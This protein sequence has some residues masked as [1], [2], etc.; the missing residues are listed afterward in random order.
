MSQQAAQGQQG[1]G[2]L[3]QIAALPGGIPNTSFIG[4]QLTTEAGSTIASG[5]VLV[6]ISGPRNGVYENS[7]SQ[8]QGDLVLRCPHLEELQETE[9]IKALWE[10]MQPSHK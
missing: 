5:K 3:Q 7:Q 1:I 2:G 6:A 4:G 10:E 8:C 9:A